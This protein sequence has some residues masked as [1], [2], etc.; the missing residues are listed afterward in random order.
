[1]AKKKTGYEPVDQWKPEPEE[2]SL[3]VS[4]RWA[5][6]PEE[7]TAVEAPAY[8]PDPNAPQARVVTGLPQG[9]LFALLDAASPLACVADAE[10]YGLVLDGQLTPIGEKVLAGCDQTY[11]RH[12]LTTDYRRAH[13]A[14]VDAD[15][16]KKE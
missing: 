10:Y 16:R 15:W 6:E 14:A 4:H 3:E 2:E 11:L 8:T 7:P 12:K 13:N 9:A 5:P 1:M